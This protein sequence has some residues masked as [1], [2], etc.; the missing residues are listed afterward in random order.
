[1]GVPDPQGGGTRGCVYLFRDPMSI[2]P[3]MGIWYAQRRPG[4]PGRGHE[5]SVETINSLGPNGA[6]VLLG[7]QTVPGM[8]RPLSAPASVRREFP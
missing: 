1:M 6:G 4:E 2:G 3:V 8:L 7:E 5:L